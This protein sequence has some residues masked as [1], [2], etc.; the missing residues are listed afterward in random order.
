MES[1]PARN[2]SSPDTRA[3]HRLGAPPRAIGFVWHNRLFPR[4]IPPDSPSC[5]SL[6]LFFQCSLQV[7][8]A[9]TPF[10]QTTCPL[11]CRDLNW[12][13]LAQKPHVPWTSSRP[14]QPGIGFVSHISP[15]AARQ[16][17][18]RRSVPNPQSRNWLRL[19]KAASSRNEKVLD[20]RTAQM[21]RIS[22]L[23]SSLSIR[24]I[25]AIRCVP[26]RK[27]GMFVRSAPQT[28]AGGPRPC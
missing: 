16:A 2:P 28:L 15:S 6:A 1:G 12:V 9:I 11:S 10:P 4:T 27:L 5:P 24:V 13:C 23:C 17:S 8:S 14:G 21:T 18:R 25:R 26:V 19:A 22:L 20:P 7:R 3:G